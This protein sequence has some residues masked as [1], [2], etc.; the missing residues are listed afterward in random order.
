MKLIERT[1]KYVVDSEN[2]AIELIK[3]SKKDAE[4]KHYTLGSSGYTYKTKKAKGEIVGEAWV[5]S[6]KK[7][8]GGVWDDYE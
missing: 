2:E 4:E 8:L 5:V 6:I 3:T 1:E 7:I